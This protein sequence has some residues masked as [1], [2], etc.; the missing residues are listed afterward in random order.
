MTSDMG[1]QWSHWPF[2]AVAKLDE[3]GGSSASSIGKILAKQHGYKCSAHGAERLLIRAVKAGKVRQSPRTNRFILKV[4]SSFGS[5]GGR[6]RGRGRRR[7]RSR[8]GKGKAMGEGEMAILRKRKQ[9]EGAA[10]LKA[11]SSTSRV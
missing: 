10:G 2:L 3:K 8:K 5:R 1:R 6:S 11:D 7:R 4:P 9:Q